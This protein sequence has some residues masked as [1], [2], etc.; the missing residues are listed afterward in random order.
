M[1]F[2]EPEPESGLLD[3]AVRPSYSGSGG[4]V[5]VIHR[6]LWSGHDALDQWKSD[7]W[8]S[9]V[10]SAAQEKGMSMSFD[11]LVEFAKPAGL[12]LLGMLTP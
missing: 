2:V 7:T 1:R 3:A 9:K 10:K 8:W 6:L 11:L 5:F 12:K 4:G